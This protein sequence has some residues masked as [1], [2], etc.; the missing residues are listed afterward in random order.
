[1]STVI[2]MNDQL[3]RTDAA[4]AVTADEAFLALMC[5][6]ED[7]VRAEFDAIITAE[8][9]P[10]ACDEWASSPGCA[11]PLPPNA[12]G[13]LDEDSAPTQDEVVPRSWG[14]ERSPPPRR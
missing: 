10:P 4:D 8:W 7:W 5:A 14:R 6:D 9:P 3:T 1:M 12:G 11:G 13:V 2:T